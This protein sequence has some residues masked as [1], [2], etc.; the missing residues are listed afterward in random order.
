MNPPRPLPP[1]ACCCWMSRAERH[2]GAAARCWALCSPERA[3]L[4]C[5]LCHAVPQD[6]SSWCSFPL[7]VTGTGQAAARGWGTPAWGWLCRGS[8]GGSPAG[9]CGAARG[10]LAA[11]RAL[12]CLWEQLLAPEG[13]PVTGHGPQ[14]CAATG[15][16]APHLPASQCPASPTPWGGSQGPGLAGGMRSPG[17]EGREPEAAWGLC[18]GAGTAGPWHWVPCPCWNWGRCLC[19][20]HMVLELPLTSCTLPGGWRDRPPQPLLPP[21]AGAL[22][23]DLHQHHRSE[24]HSPSQGLAA[25]PTHGSL[26]AWSPTAIARALALPGGPE[27]T[28]SMT[29]SGGICKRATGCTSSR[30]CPGSCCLSLG[31]HR[32]QR[33][34]GLQM[35]LLVRCVARMEAPEPLG[36]SLPAPFREHPSL[37]EAGGLWHARL[38]RLPAHTCACACARACEMQA[39]QVWT[40][41]HACACVCSPRSVCMCVRA[42]VQS[43]LC[44]HVPSKPCVPVCAHRQSRLAG[45][46]HALASSQLRG[47]PLLL[48]CPCVRDGGDLQ[49]G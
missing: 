39:G 32:G 27:A 12:F 26:R 25:L 47:D 46:H 15:P 30:G 17:A 48:V 29:L 28:P 20:Y 18:P 36:L 23:M 16:S 24:G 10:A 19:P 40:R 9:C 5:V 31:L 11:L 6:K 33:C 2:E 45:W 35:G 38:G 34:V 49:V 22:G 8:G 14:S 44:V 21:A 42:C 1:T 7:R 4:C 43:T 3:V 13:R 41:V 37:G